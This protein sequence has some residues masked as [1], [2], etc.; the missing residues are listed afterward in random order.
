MGR[1]KGFVGGEARAADARKGSI[2]LD[3]PFASMKPTFF[4]TQAFTCMIMDLEERD[5]RRHDL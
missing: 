4:L 2:P 5:G 1:E 3:M